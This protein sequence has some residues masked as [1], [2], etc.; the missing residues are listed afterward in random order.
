[1]IDGFLALFEDAQR[2]GVVTGKVKQIGY[3]PITIKRV[4]FVNI[5]FKIPVAHCRNCVP[6]SELTR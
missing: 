2:V 6:R 1:M 3:H 5:V 4:A